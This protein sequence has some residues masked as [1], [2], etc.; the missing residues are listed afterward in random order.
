MGSCRPVPTMP[1]LSLRVTHQLGEGRA[2]QRLARFVEQLRERYRAE[3]SDFDAVWNGS[4]LSVT[5]SVSGFRIRGDLTVSA[6]DVQLD[7]T[8]PLAAVV[9]RSRVEQAIRDQLG[10]ILA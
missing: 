6:T 2:V 10:E 9:F 7:G 1:R 4:A 3:L 8:L 5:L